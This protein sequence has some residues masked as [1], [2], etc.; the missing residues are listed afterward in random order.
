MMFPLCVIS[1][2]TP[3]LDGSSTRFEPPDQSELLPS[4]LLLYST[5]DQIEYSSTSADWTYQFR[6]HQQPLT[7]RLTPS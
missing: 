6:I 1:A 4:Q 7:G 3:Q 2:Q 5:G